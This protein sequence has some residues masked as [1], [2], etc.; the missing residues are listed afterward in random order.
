MIL[1]KTK[2]VANN[3][4]DAMIAKIVSDKDVSERIC[5]SPSTNSSVTLTTSEFVTSLDGNSQIISRIPALTHI[6]QGDIVLIRP[7]G[8]IYTLFRIKSDHNSLFVT[9]RCNSNCIMCSQPPRDRDDLYY[10]F[11]INTQLLNMLPS[12]T[13]ELGI[14]GGEPTLLGKRFISLLEMITDRLPHTNIHVLTNGR[15]FAWKNIPYKISKVNNPRIV[16]G[17]PLYSDYY[18]QHDFIVQAKDAFNQTVIGLHNMAHQ[19]LRLELRVVLHNQTY[20]RLPAL[21]KYVFKNFP[22]LEHIALMGLE[23][24][25]YTPR[26]HDLLWVEYN[27]YASELEEAIF[28]LDQMGMNVSIYNVQLCLLK[29]TLW[30]FARNSVSD[31]KKVYLQEC[32]RCNLLSECCGVFST[33][34]KQSN[35]IKAILS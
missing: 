34:K 8:A 4:T 9:E 1:L 6:E 13:Q 5:F 30:S 15:S 24:T 3:I 28:Y 12:T 27:K 14:T 17:I 29:P 7:D 11:E 26:N 10:F 35:E 20:Q 31:W 22:F 32:Q 19:C 23:Y 21:A 16:Y 33:S 25:G 18:L 2:G